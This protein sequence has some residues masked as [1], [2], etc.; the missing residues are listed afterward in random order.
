MP[1]RLRHDMGTPVCEGH[2][3][4]WREPY[5]LSQHLMGKRSLKATPDGIARAKRA[6]ERTG[7]TQEYLAAE[8]GLSTRQSIWKFF[9]GRPI[10]RYIFLEICFRL[11]LEWQEVADLPP[12]VSPPDAVVAGPIT[13]TEG[14]PQAGVEV[15]AIR[16]RLRERIEAQCAIV[17]SP[18]EASQ[19]LALTSIYTPPYVSL[20][21]SRQRWLEV[22]DLETGRSAAVGV[23]Q[24]GQGRLV[25][26]T[27]AIAQ[28]DR[29]TILGK[30]GS[31]KTTLLQHLAIECLDGRFRGDTLPA[32]VELRHWVARL[33]EGAP[34][35]LLDP[36]CEQWQDT[37][38]SRD[39]VTT[40]CQNGKVSVLLDGLDEVPA[41]AID[42]VVLAIQSFAE[43]FY[44]TPIALTCRL[45]T[46]GIRFRGFAYLELADFAWPQV[47]DFAKRWFVAMDATAGPARAVEFLERLERRENYSIRELVKT[48][49]LLCLI[50]SVF[51]ARSTFPTKRSKLY[52]A[53][54]DLL[55]VRW[56]S[57]RGI[58]RAGGEGDLDV[59]DKIALLGGIAAVNFEAGNC[60]FE[61]SEAVSEIADRLVLSGLVSDGENWEALWYQSEQILKNLEL[62]HG[63]LVEQARDVYSFSH[64][65]FQEY[66]TARH[67]VAAATQNPN[68][69]TV[70]RLANRFSEPR[71]RETILLVSEM[72]PRPQFL[73]KQFKA[74]VDQTIE[75]HGF[76]QG[77]LTAI[78]QKQAAIA[79]E[80]GEIAPAA[81]R[82][83]Y[84]TL[85]QTRDMNLAVAI[86]AALAQ[87]LP[88]PLM[89]DLTLARTLAACDATI[90]HPDVK[91]IVSFGML[92]DFD[93]QLS[94]DPMFAGALQGLRAD[95]PDLGAGRDVLMDWWR[96]AGP[97][98]AG[99]FRQCVA[100]HRQ[101]G[102][103]WNL[104]DDE[105]WTLARFYR[106][107]QFLIECVQAALPGSRAIAAELSQTLLLPL[108]NTR[109]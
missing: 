24:H 47:E 53:G 10:E 91:S 64:L 98:W 56:D 55:L 63:L 61:K 58:Q 66:L 93:R 41:D 75:S 90:E 15:D 1:T 80:V 59:A 100:E 104:D 92:L 65:T 27:A 12:P 3:T 67:L 23:E 89:L 39:Q 69:G 57:A 26:A 68:D 101:V 6:F 54:L 29:V 51:Q 97:G 44:A 31:G 48:P 42:A 71:W 4:Q 17:Q 72:L 34:V 95:L 14:V 11:G 46:D 109:P 88:P 22:S 35:D 7:W 78:A 16:P 20:E 84:F 19:P 62:Q 107:N 94:L 86:D 25:A 2:Q 40:L 82:A 33:E 28:R 85:F 18:L 60:F 45:A 102:W 87:E 81:V 38:L 49:I 9:T 21:L 43:A 5:N 74:R 76:L 36:I 99:Q 83:F 103:D 30:P 96:T 13:V 106:D 32:F 79:P 52:Q 8:V 77:M 105:R 108:P 37:G 50:C 70:L 73:L